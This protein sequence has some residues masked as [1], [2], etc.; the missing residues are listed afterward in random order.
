MDTAENWEWSVIVG[1]STIIGGVVCGGF[2]YA[3]VQLVKSL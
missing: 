3:L 1:M 2:F